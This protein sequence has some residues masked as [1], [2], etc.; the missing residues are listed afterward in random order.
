MPLDGDTVIG[1][2]GDAEIDKL[3]YNF[4]SGRPQITTH[5]YFK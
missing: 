2:C 5:C 1:H 4:P 3:S